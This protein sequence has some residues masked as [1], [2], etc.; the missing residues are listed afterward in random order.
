MQFDADFANNIAHIGETGI[1]MKN[2]P[3]IAL[4][5]NL[6]FRTK[7]SV[8]GHILP[9]GTVGYSGIHYKDGTVE[10]FDT[11]FA[12]NI[13]EIGPSGIVLKNGAPIQFDENLRILGRSKRHIIG[14]S[15]MLTSWGQAVQFR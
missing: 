14:D 5:E 2:G 7:R 13:A 9:A 11:E 3:P 4:D 10:L 8:A 12:H 1:I 6:H 15:G